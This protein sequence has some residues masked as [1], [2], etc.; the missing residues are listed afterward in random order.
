MGATLTTIDDILRTDYGPAIQEQLNNKNTLLGRLEKDFD[1]VSHGGK[2]F[3]FPIHVTRNE[4]IGSRAEG[5]A[6]P[7]AGA[8]GYESAVLPNKYSYARIELTGQTIEASKKNERAFV[9]ALSS[10]MKGALRDAKA[11]Q[12]R[13]CYGDGSGALAVCAS[14]SNSTTVT[15]DT[16]KWLRVGQR[17]DILVTSTGATTAGVVG[18]TV[19]SITSGT[20]FVTADAL[21]TYAS[22]DNTYSVYAAS[23]RG[24]EPYGLAA[25]IATTDTITSGLQGIAVASYPIWKSTLT[26]MG[27][28]LTELAMQ[29]MLDDIDQAGAGAVSAIYTS[30]GV[31]RAYGEL[32]TSQRMFINNAT[33]D[34]GIKAATFN[35]LP[36]YPDKDCQAGT[37]WFADESNLVNMV[38]TDWGWAEEDGAI[39]AKVTGYDKYEAYIR[40][41]RN[42]GTYERNAH[43]KLYSITEA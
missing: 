5:G 7:A 35:N 17:I 26:S 25:I 23:S 1:S 40:T 29:K 41:Y 38:M 4:G 6:L 31:N 43:G 21:A 37:M 13:Q 3:T 20:V 36:I 33:L 32:M 24:Y 8:Q 12:N 11:N 28:A 18:T 15:V 19:A 22:I 14:A 16:T 34:G 10:E 39:L 42:L 9:K 30:H 27:G 2:N